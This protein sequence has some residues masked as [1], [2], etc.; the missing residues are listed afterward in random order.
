MARSGLIEQ[1]LEIET[2]KARLAKRLR[3]TFGRSSDK[4][5]AQVEQLELALA[6]IDE[7]LAE[8]GAA[9]GAP[10][11]HT[12]AGDSKPARRPLP[13]AL[14]REVIEHAPAC[15]EASGARLVCGGMPRPLGE[16]VTE[17]LNDVTGAFRHVR[18]NL[19]CLSCGTIT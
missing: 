6:H 11:E 8:A 18:P 13:E 1:R 16:D 19:S 12:A 15:Q 4:L 14:T 17:I 2:L 3:L 10:T 9:D 5:R 7:L